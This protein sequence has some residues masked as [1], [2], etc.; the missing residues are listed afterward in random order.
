M[1]KTQWYVQR[2]ELNTTKTE[3]LRIG[4]VHDETEYMIVDKDGHR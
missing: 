2:I 1:I 4:D 3:I